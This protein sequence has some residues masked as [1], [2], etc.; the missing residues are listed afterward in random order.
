M[1]RSQTVKSRSQNCPP[2]P[3]HH[4]ANGDSAAAAAAAAAVV[5]AAA[6]ADVAAAAAAAAAY[7]RASQKLCAGSSEAVGCTIE[8]V[9]GL[10]CR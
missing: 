6:A 5:A 7:Q 10:E 8:R 3:S 2:R 1:M 9:A 4:P